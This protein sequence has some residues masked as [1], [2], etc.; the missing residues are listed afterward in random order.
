VIWEYT[1][2]EE[3]HT[4]MWSNIHRKRFY[5]AEQAPICAGTLQEEFG[6][7][8]NM[9][10][11]EQVLKGEYLLEQPIDAATQE[12]LA[13]AE[14]RKGVQEN[15][16]LTNI[17]HRQWADFWGKSKEETLSSRSGR[18]FRHSIV[19]A[20][21]KLMSH[22]HAVKTSI[23]LRGGISLEHWSQGLLVMLK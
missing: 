21:S 2:K 22:F 11:T 20:T 23:V 1:G 17:T 19:G 12:L 8:S 3:V 18:H 4:A 9:V 15:M 7:N 16:I 13:T 6:Y 14:I 5:L 10:A